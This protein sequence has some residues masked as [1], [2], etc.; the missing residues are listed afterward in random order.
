MLAVRE[1]VLVR[2]SAL[3]P[4]EVNAAM[5]L[6]RV[7]SEKY[8]KAHLFAVVAP[9]CALPDPES[10]KA[11]SETMSKMSSY[12]GSLSVVIEGRGIKGATLRSVAASFLLFSDKNMHVW[13]SLTEAVT[14]LRVKDAEEI[15]ADAS[16]AGIA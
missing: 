16:A 1:N 3:S 13:S 12:C 10:R 6:A 8:G 4:A 11:L 14:A 5:N 15:L 2:W 7:A 9:E